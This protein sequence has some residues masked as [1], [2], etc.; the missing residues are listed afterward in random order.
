MF[1]KALAKKQDHQVATASDGDEKLNQR[2]RA[3]AMS[4]HENDESITV[5]A[6]MPGVT[7]ERVEI[8]VDN[9]ILT[10]R[11]TV[12]PDVHSGFQLLRREYEMGNFERAFTLPNEIDKEA[13]AAAVSKGVL[14]VTL[15]KKKSVQPRRIR[16]EVEPRGQTLPERL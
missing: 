11:G 2:S 15:P 10:V 14:T 13:V 7:Q 1:A 8:T 12:A 6:D 3:P 16:S 9:D 4:I 5:I